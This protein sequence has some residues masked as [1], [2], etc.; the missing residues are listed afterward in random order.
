MIKEFGVW[1]ATFVLCVLGVIIIDYTGLMWTSFIGPKRENVRREIYES[2][3]SFQDG[4][5]QELN[6]LYFEY[7][8]ADETGKPAVCATVRHSVSGY[9]GQ[10]TLEEKKFVRDCGGLL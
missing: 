3:K 7:T 8:K 10:L 5:H 9:K 4:K 6:K 1:I 2:T